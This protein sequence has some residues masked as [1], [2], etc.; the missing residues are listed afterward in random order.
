MGNKVEQFQNNLWTAPILCTTE[1]ATLP[2]QKPFFLL[3]SISFWKQGKDQNGQNEIM[4]IHIYEGKAF[5]ND[6]SWGHGHSTH[7]HE[8]GTGSEFLEEADHHFLL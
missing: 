6:Q 1:E 3:H 2:K 7:V 4:E 8:A 5:G